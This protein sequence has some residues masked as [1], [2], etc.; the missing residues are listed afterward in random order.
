MGICMIGE[1]IVTDAVWTISRS[2]GIPSVTFAPPCPA[3]WNVLRV[4]CV[5]GSPIPCAASTPTASPASARDPTKRAVMI[6]RNR[7][8][9]HPAALRAFLLLGSFR[10][11]SRRSLN[12]SDVEPMNRPGCSRLCT[13]SISTP[14][15]HPQPGS[16]SWACALSQ[17]FT[18]ASSSRGTRFRPLLL[19]AT[20][21]LVMASRAAVRRATAAR[22]SGRALLEPLPALAMAFFIAAVS[23]ISAC[24]AR[25][26]WASS[27]SL[28]RSAR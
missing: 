10:K 25:Q 7:F 22:A 19:I 4:I 27:S 13:G 18:S 17:F 24:R 2:L 11:L 9:E 3:K 28:C 16:S 20:R 14:S 5:E 12:T 1:E 23:G 21:S 15:I 26:A 8:S 6:L